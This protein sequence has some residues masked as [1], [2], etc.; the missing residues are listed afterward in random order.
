[1]VQHT[2]LKCLPSVLV[3]F[4]EGNLTNLYS[5]YTHMNIV[6]LQHITHSN[7]Q[8]CELGDMCTANINDLMECCH[9]LRIVTLVWVKGCY[10]V[11]NF[12]VSFCDDLMDYQVSILLMSIN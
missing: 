5:K 9:Y 12:S 8:H 6:T 4:G 1:M 3:R 2:K 11:W 10:W 7:V